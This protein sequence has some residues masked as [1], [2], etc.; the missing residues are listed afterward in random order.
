MSQLMCPW[1]QGGYNVDSIS[2]SAF[3][4]VDV[5]LGTPPELLPPMR[6]SGS[7]TRTV[8]E[9]AREHSNYWHSINASDC[10]PAFGQ[11]R[12]SPSSP[13]SRVHGAKRGLTAFLASLSAGCP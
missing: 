13:P 7:A 3:A 1:L 5:L 6:A 11:S 2:N 12:P 10:Q 8:W 9:V 4:C